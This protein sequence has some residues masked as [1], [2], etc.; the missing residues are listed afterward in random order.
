MKSTLKSLFGALSIGALLINGA[1]F[2]QS[3]VPQVQSIGPNDL[4]IAAHAIALDLPLVTDNAQEFERVP[5]LRV[6]RWR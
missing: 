3:L 4:F 6:V 2:A 5:G 1:A